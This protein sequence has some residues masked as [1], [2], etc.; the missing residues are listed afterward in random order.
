MQDHFVDEY[1]PTIEDSYRKQIT[2]TCTEDIVLIDVLDTA[3]PEE[4]SAM[5]DQYLR[6]GQV[7]LVAYSIT[8]RSSFEEC[9]TFIEQI[10]RVKDMDYVPM[11]LVATKQDLEVERQVTH[12]EGTEFALRNG[13]YF[14][15]TSARTG[16]G[17]QLA[18]QTCICATLEG[19]FTPTPS[20]DKSCVVQ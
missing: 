6:T 7:F 4:Y 15:E 20:K 3:G 8:S 11:I 13:T 5:R 12:S 9:I 14:V 2:S 1:Y 17:V 16:Y 19:Q 10:R 18:F